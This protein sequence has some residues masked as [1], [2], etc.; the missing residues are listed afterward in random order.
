MF[1]NVAGVHLLGVASTSQS[2]RNRGP[3][4]LAREAV[5]AALADAGLAPAEVDGVA[6]AGADRAF[7]ASAEAAL[8]GEPRGYRCRCGLGTERR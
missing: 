7:A 2:R 5:G 3:S 1:A 4:V 8:G 6:I